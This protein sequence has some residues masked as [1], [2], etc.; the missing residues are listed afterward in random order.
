MPRKNDESHQD[1]K[2]RIIDPIS[3]SFCAA[4]WYNATIW[5]GHGQTA[6]C[7][8]PPGHWI[9][10]NELAANPS[11][12]HN[13]QHK[14]LMRKMMLE[15]ERPQECEYCW[16]VEDIGRDNASDR[17]FKTEIYKDEDIAALTQMPWDADVNLKTLEIAFDRAC[18]FACSYCNPAF[19][20]TWVKD[21]KE[22]GAYKNILSDGR[23][24]FVDTAP[25][26]ARKSKHEEDNPYIVAFWKWWN[27]GLSNS[28]EEIRITGGE[29]LMHT[30]VWKLFEWFEQHPDSNMR[31]A[32]NSN[33]VPEKTKTLDKL[34]EASHNVRRLEIYTSNESV[35]AQS[36]YIRDGMNYDVWLANLHR[37][38][39]E[40]NVYKIHMMMTINSLC[41]ESI[42]DFMDDMLVLRREYK[43]RSPSMTLNI[44]RFPSFQSAAILPVELKSDFRSRLETWLTAHRQELYHHE[45]WHVERLIDYLDV[46]KTPHRNTAEQDKLYND[47]RYFYEQYDVR[48][49]KNFLETFPTF[50]NWYQTLE[51]DPQKVYANQVAARAGDPATLDTYVNDDILGGWNT[52]EDKL[53]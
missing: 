3:D 50:S 37:L 21:I 16:K 48:R 39:K 18:N 32:I 51:Y 20:S 26:A 29:P 40:S 25:W 30:S 6:S 8:H 5:L 14:K 22:N 4:K 49:G 36:E 33:L 12:I 35:G 31:F 2:K 23:G 45:I 15:G 10:E 47:F 52:K 11:A 41:L 43:G 13:T 53:G 42:T 7:H 17:I 24:H 46:V 27:G 44:L 34:I 9:D 28:L 1:Y 38:L 19:S